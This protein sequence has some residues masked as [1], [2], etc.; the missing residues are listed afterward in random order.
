MTGGVGWAWMAEVTAGAAG[1]VSLY[2]DPVGG[3]WVHRVPLPESWS[4]LL[5]TGQSSLPV[6]PAVADHL[7]SSPHFVFLHTR[8]VFL[9]LSHKGAVCHFFQPRKWTSF[10]INIALYLFY[11][12]KS[13]LQLEQVKKNTFR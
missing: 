13:I 7:V 8:R 1:G 2:W 3:C 6:V 9:L 5:R 12:N 4:S 10:K 11:L